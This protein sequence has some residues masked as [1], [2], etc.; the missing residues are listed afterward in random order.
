MIY[1]GELGIQYPVKDL[2]DKTLMQMSIAAARDMYEK[3]QKRLED[4]NT[5]YGD[6]MS[7]IQKDM[8]WYNQNVTGKVRDT[9]NN[10]YANGIDPLRSAEGRAAISQLIY[11]MPTGDIAKVRQSA[12]NAKA[13]NKAK[14]ELQAKGLYNPLLEPYDGTPMSEF[15]TLDDGVWDRMSPTPYQNMAVFS[16]DYFDNIRS[17]VA[18]MKNT[19]GRSGGASTAGVFLKEFVKNSVKWAHLDVAGTAFLEKPQHE[20]IKGAT[21]IGVRTLINYIL[22][23][24][25]KT[26]KIK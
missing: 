7:P 1:A 18:D 25:Q 17:D 2:Y 23:S 19:G 26:E 5:K 24:K 22:E 8:D 15:S 13:F 6:F 12:E 11:S 3:G 4:F 20:L 16:K 14:L 9:I 21:G 10:L